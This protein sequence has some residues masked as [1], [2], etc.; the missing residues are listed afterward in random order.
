LILRDKLGDV[1]SEEDNGLAW[2]ACDRVCDACVK[3]VRANPGALWDEFRVLLPDGKQCLGFC[4]TDAKP[5][6]FP[7]APPRF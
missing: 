5:N 3:V 6:G 1:E 2:L 4:V 7:D